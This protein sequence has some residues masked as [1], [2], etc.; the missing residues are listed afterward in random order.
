MQETSTTA[1]GVR[2]GKSERTRQGILEAALR[3]VAR[4]GVDAVTHRSVAKEAGLTHGTLT[5]HFAS[6]DDIVLAAFRQYIATYLE[7]LEALFEERA[8][9]GWTVVDF[10][11]EL[12]KRQ[13][14]E[15]ELLAA[16]Y[17][18]ILYASRNDA[19]A[20]EYQ[21]W[22]RRMESE[23]AQVLEEQGA[24]RPREAA[25]I[26]M[27]LTRAFELSCLTEPNKKPADL[28]RQLERVLPALVGRHRETSR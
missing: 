3:V 13:L 1:P 15:R 21:R 9:A 22:Q 5:Y 27:G 11:V 17:E 19:L 16:E 20:R 8:E 25:R 7:K 4:G 18:L 28:G 2:R 26:I 12:Q 14:R 10:S 23:I 6:R 24:T